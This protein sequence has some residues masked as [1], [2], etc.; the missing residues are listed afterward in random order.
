MDALVLKLAERS[1]SHS[2][3]SALFS[4]KSTYLYLLNEV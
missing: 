1:D 4:I 3:S 2:F